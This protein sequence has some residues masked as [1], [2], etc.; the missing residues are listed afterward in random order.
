MAGGGRRRLDAGA[1]RRTSLGAIAL[2]VGVFA[3]LAVVDVYGPVSLYDLAPGQSAA[4]LVAVALAAYAAST[5]ARGALGL[6]LVLALGGVGWP[7]L[8]P[9][10]APAS[11]GPF[12]WLGDAVGEAVSPLRESFARAA[13]DWV[14]PAWGGAVLAAGFWLLTTGL[15]AG[16][17]RRRR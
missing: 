8:R 2:A 9:W 6:A 4:V 3:P 1:R 7:L 15:L 14:A 17:A 10:V 12:D 13:L 16:P 11:R 5:G